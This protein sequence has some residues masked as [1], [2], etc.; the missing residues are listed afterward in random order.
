[1]GH[2]GIKPAVLFGEKTVKRAGYIEGYLFACEIR[3]GD[4]II[5]SKPRKPKYHLVIVVL[6][7]T[8][9][10]I[11]NGEQLR[12]EKQSYINLPTWV[13]IYEIE[14][15]EDFHAM[16]TATDRNLIEDIFRNRNPF[17]QDFGFSINHS[18]G[19]DIVNPK[20]MQTLKR[21]ISNMI[22]ALN[23]KDHRF[24]EEINYA[25]F[26]ILLTD[27]ADMMWT[28]YGKGSP[29]HFSDMTRSD[30]IL[31]D[32]TDLLKEHIMTETSVGFYAE[33]LCISKKYLSLI[34]KNKTRVSIGTII[35]IIRMETASR[36]LR[37]PEM[38]IQQ[39]ASAMSFSDQ[40]SFGKFF[41]KH[42]GMS[43]L[44]YRQNLRKTL[45]TL[46]PA[47]IKYR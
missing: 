34:V 42:T 40:S 44:K 3:G 23:D 43:P 26:Y 17:P 11:V 31:R 15:G 6:E 32:F 24:A 13:D 37:D 33:K 20:D 19:G 45:L 9:D 36:M 21:D 2:K 25:Y 30:K 16:V 12:F 27:M 7:G 28:M 5:Y 8:I 10:L 38:T 46:R 41:K 22:D 1:M 47:E 4:H 35:S 14:Y 18:L 39:I 29:S